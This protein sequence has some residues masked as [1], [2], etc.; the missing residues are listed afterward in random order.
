MEYVARVYNTIKRK[1]RLYHINSPDYIVH[2][3]RM[4]KQLKNKLIKNK[5]REA[6]DIKTIISLITEGKSYIPAIKSG[7]DLVQE[8]CTELKPLFESLSDQMVKNT[9]KS[10]DQYKAAGFTR[11]EAILLTLNTKVALSESLKSFDT[12]LKNKQ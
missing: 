5:R 7:V 9:V 10:I 4:K 2:V 8:A 12:A 3:R 1:N 6:M 11:D